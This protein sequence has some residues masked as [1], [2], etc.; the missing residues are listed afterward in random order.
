MS[1][2]DEREDC[3]IASQQYS[4]TQVSSPVRGHVQKVQKGQ[5]NKKE[6]RPHVKHAPSARVLYIVTMEGRLRP[7]PVAG[8]A[9][10]ESLP[11]VSSAALPRWTLNRGDIVTVDIG[12][13]GQGYAKV[14]DLRRL[15]DGRYV[16]VY[17]W[18]YARSQIV[19]KMEIDADLPAQAQVNIDTMWPPNAAH[20]LMLSTN[21]TITMWDTAIARAPR[22]ITESICLYAI[23]NTT[24]L[25]RQI[26]GVDHPRFQWMREILI[27]KPDVK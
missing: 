11:V 5:K 24:T 2:W 22:I 15:S 19:R 9:A 1:H 21:R 26:V 27:M 8:E 14:S 25:S 3:R 12:Q 17:A 13:K 7:I 23:Y 16:V 18:L 6:A 20:E 4:P 10:W